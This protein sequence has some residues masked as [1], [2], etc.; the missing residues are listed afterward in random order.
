MTPGS[1]GPTRKSRTLSSPSL[2]CPTTTA[3]LSGVHETTSVSSAVSVSRSGGEEPSVGAAKTSAAGP[4]RDQ[5]HATQPPSGETCEPN[6][7]GTESKASRRLRAFMA[8]APHLEGGRGVDVDG[9]DGLVVGPPAVLGGRGEVERVS[10]LDPEG[11]V[12]LELD[13]EDAGDDVHELL[14][15][16][17][18]ETLAP[19]PWRNPDV[20]WIHDLL[21]GGHLLEAHAVVPL[22]YGS[23]PAPHERGTLLQVR[24]EELPHCHPVGLGQSPQRGDRS[25]RAAAFERR[26]ERDGEVR[27]LRHLLERLVR[28]GAQPPQTLPHHVRRPGRAVIHFPPG[29]GA[30]LLAYRGEV[31]ALYLPELLDIAQPRDVRLGVDP[32]ASIA[33]PRPHK[34]LSLPQPQSL[35]RQAYGLRDRAYGE[36]HRTSTSI[37]TIG[38]QYTCKVAVTVPSAPRPLP[39]S[40]Q[41]YS[42]LL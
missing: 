30:E 18:V 9:L 40:L 13:E 31:Q 42:S 4:S 28:P 33:A 22:H 37:P 36:P 14:A 17:R 23:V 3:R 8:R 1:S 41:V 34:A 5:L 21:S 7:A 10:G 16:V 39:V 26:D 27:G 38:P 35:R 32:V 6:R 19:G 11:A 25:S 12:V 29:C 24:P 15:V 20:G 2:S